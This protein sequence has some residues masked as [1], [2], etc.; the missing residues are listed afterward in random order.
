MVSTDPTPALILLAAR[1]EHPLERLLGERGFAVVRAPSGTLAVDWARDVR[2]DILILESTLPDMSGLDACQ[3]VRATPAF[4]RT[5]P[6]LLLVNGQPSPADHVLALRTGIWDF[7]RYPSDMSEIQL[8]IETY[9]QTKRNIEKT[10]SEILVDTRTG[11]H[12]RVGL[13]RRARE[14]A[15]L[16]SRMHGAMSCVVFALDF[17]PLDASRAGRSITRASRSSDV[18]GLLSTTEFGIL[19]P[20][21]D[22]AGAVE[23]TRRLGAVLRTIVREGSAISES[24]TVTA[25]I[26]SVPN[27]KYAPMEPVLLIA[28]ASA[29]A[30]SGAPIPETPWIRRFETEDRRDQ[31]PGTL[32]ATPPSAVDVPFR[33]TSQ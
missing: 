14:L 11:L 33:R 32:S 30:R 31:V 26:E 6:I 22:G 1:K 21:T 25:G 5:V 13:S 23:M 19:A 29:A 20:G 8:M 28:R 10:H 15:A 12:S 16:M 24:A 18:I 4:G 3:L 2:P 17:E 7:L 27:F 9:L